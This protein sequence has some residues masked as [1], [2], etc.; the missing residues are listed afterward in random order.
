MT[1]VAAYL[2][3]QSTGRMTAISLLESFTA[4]ISMTA[5]AAYL[6]Y[7]CAE[8]MLDLGLKRAHGLAS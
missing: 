8:R 4:K 2:T 7:K 6:T 1:G 3:Y 5:T